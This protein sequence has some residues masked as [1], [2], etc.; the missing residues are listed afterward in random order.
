M[1]RNFD[2][3]RRRLALTLWSL[4]VVIWAIFAVKHSKPEPQ[5]R[6]ANPGTRSIVMKHLQIESHGPLFGETNVNR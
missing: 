6:R 1:N 4:A 2:I 5:L 3:K